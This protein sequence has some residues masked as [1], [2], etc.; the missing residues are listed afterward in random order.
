MH[1]QHTIGRC[2]PAVL[3]VPVFFSPVGADAQSADGTAASAGSQLWAGGGGGISTIGA[4]AFFSTSV[5]FLDVHL[6]TVRGLTSIERQ[7]ELPAT[8][9]PLE[10]TWEVGVLYGRTLFG[11]DRA[12]VTASAGVGFVGGS[13]GTRRSLGPNLP[14]SSLGFAGPSTC[15]L[16][17]ALKW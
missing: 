7:S 1:P 15:M 3:L 11:G 2:L 10:N 6:L 17:T 13:F 9:R 5:G 16:A 4:G 14:S 12:T 8:K